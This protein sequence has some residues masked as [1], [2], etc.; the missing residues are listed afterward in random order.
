MRETVSGWPS[1]TCRKAS[2]DVVLQSK[3]KLNMCER[4][5][6][7]FLDLLRCIVGSLQTAWMMACGPPHGLC[8]QRHGDERPYANHVNHVQGCGFAQAM[9]RVSCG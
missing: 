2:A 7:D 6:I 1:Y 5:F 3:K 4:A 9:S 8:D